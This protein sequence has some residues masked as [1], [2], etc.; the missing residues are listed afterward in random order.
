METDD[1][2]RRPFRPGAVIGGG[3]LLALGAGLL[4]DRTGV[5]H[6]HNLTAPLVLI[7]LGALTTFEHSRIVY[8]VPVKDDE[9]KL[10]FQTRARRTP[11]SG[12]WLIWI[13]VW[14]LISQNHL[15][16]FTFQTSWPLFLVLM[17]IMMVLRGWR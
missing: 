8:S 1:R 12:L 15:W 5:L 10:K 2:P 13:G 16:G 3:V 4:V 14:M 7:V 11:G 6:L 17:G 9:G